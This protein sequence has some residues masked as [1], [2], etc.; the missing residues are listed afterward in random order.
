MKTVQI[1]SILILAIGCASTSGNKSVSFV[2]KP[3]DD[4]AK[5]ATLGAE[6]FSF[7]PGIGKSLAKSMLENKA[8]EFK[9]DTI[10]ITKEEGFFHSKIN[11][12]GYRCNSL[13]VRNK[14]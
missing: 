11:A 7:I 6:G 5:V 12:D 8:G 4:C 13:A 1:L 10:V 3:K 14:R 9:A 2:E